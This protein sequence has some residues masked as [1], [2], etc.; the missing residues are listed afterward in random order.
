MA[1]RPLLASNLRHRVSIAAMDP[2]FLPEVE[3]I[4]QELGIPVCEPAS[5]P[6]RLLLTLDRLGLSLADRHSGLSGARADWRSRSVKRRVAAGRRQQIGRATGLHTRKNVT[7]LDGCAGLGT[8]GFV[9]ACLGAEVTMTERH[10]VICTLLRDALSRIREDRPEWLNSPLNLEVRQMDALDWLHACPPGEQPEAIYLDPMYPARGKTALPGKNMQ[11]LQ[12][13]LA[14]V[15]RDA[16]RL[17]ET[18]LAHARR[19]VVV[20]RPVHSAPLRARPDFSRQGASTR[21]D[22]Y[23]VP[24]QA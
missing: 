18:A 22:V 19:R 7:I 14:E 11:I 1:T 12:S 3:S 16:G 4:A 24:Q 15:P 9:L 17:L 10:P 13:L 20:K 6:T 5:C 23:L 21:Y 8:D 2:A